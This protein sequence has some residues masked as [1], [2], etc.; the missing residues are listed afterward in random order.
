HD[1][2]AAVAAGTHVIL[3]G[4]TNTEREY[5]PTVA[6][7]LRSELKTASDPVLGHVEVI[8]SQVDVHPLQF[9]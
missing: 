8:I 2:L 4:H 1:V 7:K 3:C 6:T 9:V 5:L